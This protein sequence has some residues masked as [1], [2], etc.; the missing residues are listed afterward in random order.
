MRRW[1]RSCEP[2]FRDTGVGTHTEHETGHCVSIATGL[3][4]HSPLAAQP[5]Q[6]SGSR[7]MQS[8]AESSAEF[9]ATGG[10]A[11][12][13]RG[14][15]P[16]RVGSVGKRS[17]RRG[18]CRKSCMSTRSMCPSRRER[19][20]G[21]ILVG[22]FVNFKRSQAGQIDHY[23]ACI[24]QPS[25]CLFPVASRLQRSPRRCLSS[26]CLPGAGAKQV[27]CVFKLEFAL[28]SQRWRQFQQRAAVVAFTGPAS[29]RRRTAR[30]ATTRRGTHARLRRRTVRR[31]GWPSGGRPPPAA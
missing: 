2:E 5:G 22:K 14:L 28:L 4:L 9:V 12:V 8:T 6:S 17:W 24:V 18:S 1:W 31:R 15:L 26:G 19:L 7:S 20:V 27:A 25:T 23:F 29:R 13:L 10:V 30:A 3:L 11:V 16:K 21:Q